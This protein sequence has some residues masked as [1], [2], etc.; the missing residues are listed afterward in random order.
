MGIRTATEHLVKVLEHFEPISVAEVIES[1]ATENE[2]G[3]EAPTFA[4]ERAT[5]PAPY[6]TTGS[7]PTRIE[8]DLDGRAP[9]EP[10]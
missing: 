1:G 5:V 10:S 6:R 4:V 9:S 3:T 2:S 7:R 8:A